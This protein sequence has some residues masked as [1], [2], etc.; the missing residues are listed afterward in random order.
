MEYL[1]GMLAKTE[2]LEANAK[3]LQDT[4]ARKKQLKPTIKWTDAD[5]IDH[6]FEKAGKQNREMNMDIADLKQMVQDARR[7]FAV[8]APDGDSDG[9]WKEET[10]EINHIIEDAALHEDTAAI[11]QQH[12]IDEAEDQAAKKIFA[13]DA[14][15][16]DSDGHFR[17]EMEEIKIV[18][19][20][21][22]EFK[23]KKSH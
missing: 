9:H 21:A 1:D 7:V 19:E 18:I 10:M 11:E 13:V 3:G 23:Y 16:G 14:P 8:A 22:A 20:D 15:D 6:L 2:E 4:Y 17:E 12:R 5:E